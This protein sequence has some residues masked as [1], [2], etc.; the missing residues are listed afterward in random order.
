MISRAL[1]IVAIILLI[2]TASADRVIV[3]LKDEINSKNI[4]DL[5]F[6]VLNYQKNFVDQLRYYE[7]I[8][9]VKSLK[10]LWIVNSIV[11]DATPDVID[12]I[13]NRK[14]VLE[15][16]PDYE[17]KLKEDTI[18]NIEMLKANI[19]WKYGI[20]GSG[21][22]VSIVDTG[23][24]S[25]HPDL[26]GKIIAWKDLV[27][28]LS[29]PYDDN[30]HGTHVAGTVAGNKT[31]IAPEVRLIGVKVFD[32][33]GY[34]NISTVIEGFQ[35]SAENG[36]D[37]IS[38]SGGSL[39]YMLFNNSSIVHGVNEHIFNVYTYVNEPAF[40]PALIL[41]IV[42][43][44][45]LSDLDIS[46]IAPNGS[47][48]Q[49]SECSINSELI[50]R[51]YCK[52]PIP[53]GTWKF[54]VKSVKEVEYDYWIF[55]VYPSDGTSLIDQ[56]VNNLSR[57]GIVVVCAAGNEG[58]LGFRTINAPASAKYAIAVGAVDS[59]GN[60]A[61]FSSKGPTGWGKNE[62]IKPDVVA[63]GVNII[64]TWFNGGYA[65]ASGTSMATPH[66]SGVVALMLQAN[67]SLTYLSS[68]N[69]G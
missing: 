8:G 13:K 20:N 2:S 22:N 66:V 31:G 52:D 11:V 67:E 38:F 45:N 58:W 27:N 65:Y 5:K 9:K 63:P 14:E 39:P 30:G 26:R 53:E 40:K 44:S 69:V 4:S 29:Y 50:C 68:H 43:S 32:S 64:S 56:T 17:V 37:I 48:V 21:I 1:V 16:I 18:W 12:F 3:V 61:Y 42:N 49:W 7:K 33:Y 57:N 47:S 59:S 46:L 25:S 54:R 35:W 15:V 6:K 62:T 51:Y 60:L 10:Q 28:H 55:V 34:A 36:A 23:I 41:V 19:V 24:N